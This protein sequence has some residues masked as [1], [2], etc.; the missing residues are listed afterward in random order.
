MAGVATS[1]RQRS[2][3]APYLMIL[4]ALVYLGVFYAVP[5]V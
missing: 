1:T 5:F 3:I 2:L 4:P